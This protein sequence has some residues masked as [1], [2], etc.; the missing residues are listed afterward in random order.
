MKFIDLFVTLCH[1]LLVTEAV[2]VEIGERC[3][4]PSCHPKDFE[5]RGRTECD[6]PS[7]YTV[8]WF[9]EN[10]IERPEPMSCLF[11][12]RGLSRA[13][14]RY[15][16]SRPEDEGPPLTTIWDVWPKQ[17]YSKRI[18][19]TN[20]L[21]CIMQDKEKQVQYYSTMS[22]A[23]ASM[24][25]VFAI[26][27]D[28]SI[29]LDAATANDVNQH[30][31]WFHAEFPTL[32]RLKQVTMIEAISED[33]G[34]RLKYWTSSDMVATIAHHEDVDDSEK[35]AETFDYDRDRSTADDLLVE[36]W[37]MNT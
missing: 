37:D 32:Q 24:C 2:P 16:K 12:T 13:A 11:Y 15:A 34:K 25:Y 14:R 1:L 23:F 3:A 10:A 20:P 5:V 19:T 6:L 22:K 29:G 21:R 33:G 9:I 18:T 8:E 28:K 30:G 27:M 35:R 26:V 4:T 36:E 31:L 17:Y 7:K